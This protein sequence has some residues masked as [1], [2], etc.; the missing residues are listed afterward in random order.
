MNKLS[1][2]ILSLVLISSA[3]AEHN[4]VSGKDGDVKSS[5]SNNSLQFSEYN[6]NVV[7]ER[8]CLVGY[9]PT[10]KISSTADGY[11]VGSHFSG[12]DGASGFSIGQGARARF[13]GQPDGNGISFSRTPAC[14]TEGTCKGLTYNRVSNEGSILVLV[15]IDPTS[16][17]LSTPTG[18][19]VAGPIASYGGR[20][21]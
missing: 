3:K 10:L 11:W 9:N 6:I 4:V 16:G 14:I 12:R 15:S 18:S 20:N 21:N 7:T 5:R 17:A 13:D 19:A 1:L 8:G 2:L